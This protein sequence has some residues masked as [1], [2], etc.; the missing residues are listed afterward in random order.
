MDDKFDILK[1]KNDKFD[2]DLVSVNR[3]YEEVV[4]FINKNVDKILVGLLNGKSIGIIFVNENDDYIKNIEDIIN[5]FNGSIVFN[6][7][8]KENIINLEKLKEML[9]KLGID[10]KNVND[11]VNYIIDI[12][13]KEDVS[14]ILIY[15]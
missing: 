9:I 4:N 13:K 15:F 11:V 5:K 7:I 3:D 8:L 12:F 2:S 6:I 14:D 1:E 10:V